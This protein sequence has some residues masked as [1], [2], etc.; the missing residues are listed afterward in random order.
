MGKRGEGKRRE[1]WKQR[2]ESMGGTGKKTPEGSHGV[3][4]G[5]LDRLEDARIVRSRTG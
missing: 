1:K 3:K 2:Y 4:L 5:T